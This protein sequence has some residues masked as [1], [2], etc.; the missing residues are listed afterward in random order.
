[1][2]SILFEP[3]IAGE[4]SSVLAED[5][6][7]EVLKSWLAADV[8]GDDFGPVVVPTVTDG[9]LGESLEL[10]GCVPSVVSPLPPRSFPLS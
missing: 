7:I 3:P 10:A 6:F 4:M 9:P 2:D 5:P 1:L 8:V